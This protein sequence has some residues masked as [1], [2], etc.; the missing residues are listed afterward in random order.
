MTVLL[1]LLPYMAS[2]AVSLGVAVFAWRRRSVTGALALACVA[3]SQALWTLGYNFELLSGTLEG[4]IFWDNVQFVAPS[5]WPLALLAFALGY[6]GRRLTRPRLVWGI[7]VGSSLVFNLIIVTDGWHGLLHPEARLIPGVPFDELTYEFHPIVWFFFTY[8]AIVLVWSIYLLTDQILRVQPLYRAQAGL[9]A[10]GTLVSLI[11]LTLSIM[12]V[13]LSFHRDTTPLT[14]AVSNLLVAIGLFRYHLV[15]IA[16]V[17]HSVIFESMQDPV[18]V[19]DRQDRVVDLNPAAARILGRESGEVLGQPVGRV[20]A[21][22]ISL[23]PDFQLE[24]GE[25]QEVSFARGQDHLFYELEILPMHDSRGIRVGRLVVAHDVTHRRQAEEAIRGQAKLLEEANKEL[26]AFSYSVSHDLR[27]PLRAISGYARILMEE[28]AA[29]LSPEAQDHLKRVHGGAQR[30][31]ELISDLL[32]FSRLSRQPLHKEVV[33]PAQVARQALGELSGEQTG[34]EVEVIIAEMPPCQADPALLRRVYA[35]LLDNALKFTR[36]QPEAL[37][38]VGWEQQD[39]EA[40]YYVRD[41]GVGFD[42]RYADRLFTVFQRLHSEGEYEGVGA[43]LAIVQR[44]VRR[45]GG[46]VW[47]RSEVGQGAT[48]SFTLGDE[49]T[50]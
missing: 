48:F 18:V 31:N 37:I 43:G 17:A 42:M 50:P 34:W 16:P 28:H 46:R 45:H 20:F 19:L 15:D 1:A 22:F 6:S 30:M 10:V 35:N 39:G 40:V 14:F 27:A 36:E 33:D 21:S 38:E 5:L 9:V 44:I 3:L 7:L 11:G 24:D 2:A 29:E 4:K 49:A 8:L 25:H 23:A 32:E 41:N 47:A 13:T 26:E 12:G